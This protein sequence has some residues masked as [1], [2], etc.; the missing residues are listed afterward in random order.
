[1]PNACFR[2]RASIE[3][4]GTFCADCDRVVELDFSYT[5][6]SRAWVG[7]A[8]APVLVGLSI[9]AALL[10]DGAPV[11]LTTVFTLASLVLFGVSLYTDAGHVRRRDD[12]TWNPNRWAYAAIAVL[13]PLL[14]VPVIPIT[15]YHLFRRHRAI[16]LSLGRD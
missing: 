11:F 10:V 12:T 7:V 8:V 6:E 2:C 4:G 13:G 16:G 15:L 1:M 9:G 3:S 5:D 14:V